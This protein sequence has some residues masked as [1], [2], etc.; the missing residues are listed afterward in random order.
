MTGQLYGPATWPLSDTNW[1]GG[2]GGPGLVWKIPHKR[3]I[4]S[5]AG[6]KI[7]ILLFYFKIEQLV[8]FQLIIMQWQTKQLAYMYFTSATCFD[9]TVGHHHHHHHHHHHVTTNCIK[10]KW[11]TQNCI[12][13]I[14]ISVLQCFYH[15]ALHHHHHHH[16]LWLYSPGLVFAS[17]SKCRQWLLCWA[18]ARQ[19]IQPSFL[20]NPSWFQ[21]ATSSLTSRVCPQ[22]I[23][24]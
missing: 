22:Y 17:S 2:W 13:G 3:N 12:I 8:V 1:R 16:H 7:T 21:S 18:F 20:V 24:G 15:A 9:L 4:S 11:N 6:N 5:P 14:E 19:F 23:Y 10:Y